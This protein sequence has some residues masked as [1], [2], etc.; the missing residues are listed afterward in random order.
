VRSTTVPPHRA[1]RIAADAALG[2]EDRLQ[3]LSYAIGR[4]GVR[5]YQGP[6]CWRCGL[7]READGRHDSLANCNTWRHRDGRGPCDQPAQHHTFSP[8]WWRLW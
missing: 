5:I 2:L 3:R 1:R 8:R 7:D 6:R 4:W